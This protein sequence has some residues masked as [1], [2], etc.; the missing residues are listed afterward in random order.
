MVTYSFIVPIYNDGF[1]AEAFCNEFEPMFKDYLSTDD[2]S[3][4]VELIFVNDGSQDDSI[5]EL[6]RLSEIHPFVKVID[7]S[8]NFQQHVA[9]TCGYHHAQGQYVGMLN[10]D[11]QDPPSQ[12]PLLLD[13]LTTEDVDIAIGV[14]AKQLRPWI[15]KVTSR[16]FNLLLNNLTGYATP[17]NVATLRVMNRQFVDAYNSLSEQSPFIPG[18]EGWLGFKKSYVPI[19]HRVRQQSQSSYSF[20]KRLRMAMEGVISF[21]DLP[22]R[23]AVV[24]G[25]VCALLGCGMA[26]IVVI[27]RLFFLEMLPGYTTI[28]AIIFFTFGVL[29]LVV[30][31]AGLYIGRI[32]KEVQNRPLYLIRRTYCLD[33]DPVDKEP[34]S[35]ESGKGVTNVD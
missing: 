13:V 31:V 19:E 34:Q 17:P 14:R 32:L 23:L 27:E 30:G 5:K 16:G 24:F 22:L 2:I 11:M 10:I 12:I 3:E 26:G 9:I 15:E 35:D 28:F 29:V 7:L 21:S 20:F 18:L 1:L 4:L 25:F 33:R 6:V 8:R